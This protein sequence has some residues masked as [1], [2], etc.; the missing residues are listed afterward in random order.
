[1]DETYTNTIHNE[2]ED[3]LVIIEGLTMYL[4]EIDIKKIFSIIEHAF[5]NVTIMVEMMSPFMVKH[6]KEKSIEGS[7]AKFTWGIKNGKETR[8]NLPL[9]FL[10]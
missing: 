1:M 6:I 7:H 10:F 9:H 4:T 5:S 2:G 8:K 3:V